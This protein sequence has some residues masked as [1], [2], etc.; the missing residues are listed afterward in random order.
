MRAYDPVVLRLAC[1]VRIA[2]TGSALPDRVLDNRELIEL[3]GLETTDAWIQEHIGV[4]RRGWA[5]PSQAT[6]DLAVAAGRRALEAAGVGAGELARIVLATSSGDWPTPATAC[7]VQSQLGARCAAEDKLAAC[8]GFLFALDHGARLVSTGESPVLVIGADTKSRFLDRRDRLTCSIFGD[9]AGAAVLVADADRSRGIL[10][11]ELWTDGAHAEA[12]HVPAGGSRLPASAETVAAGLHGTRIVD[13]AAAKLAAVELQRRFALALLA[14]Q[15]LDARD[16][17]WFI[18]HQANQR[19]V[20]ATAD[21]LGFSRQRT[22]SN[23]RTCGNTVAAGL[24]MGLDELLR[25]RRLERGQRVLLTC[26]GA[27]FTGGA[28]LLRA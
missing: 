7:A 24:A 21:A 20:E 9:A 1:G 22:L 26:V 19:I 18:P 11:S 27:G 3:L 23:V 10:D 17:D 4:E 13:A 14:R 8:A 5:D 16:V 6:S 25:E 2:G 12:I 15:S 28:L